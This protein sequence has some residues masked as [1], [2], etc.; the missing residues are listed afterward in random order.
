M[1]DA[2]E[3]IDLRSDT[4]TTPSDAMRE[5]AR[6]ADV[7]DD[8]Y[9]DDPTVNELERRAAEA[10]GT[11]AALYVPS[12]TMANQIAVH[13]HTEPGQ[14]LLLE[15]ESHIY[16]WELGGASK[17]SGVQTRTID[18][19]DR[20]VPTP[21]AVTEGL[22]DEDL[23]RPGTGLLSLENTHNY[24]GGTAIPVDEI[25]AAADAARDADVPVHLD[26]ARVFNAA[27]ALGVDASEIVAPVDSVT[28]CLSKG[29]GAPVGS[30]LAGDEAFVE[31]ARR[32][33]KLFG[34]GMRQAGMIAAPGLLA[35][36]NVD[37]LADDHANAERLAA[38]LDALGGVDVPEPD[39]NI[40]VV[41]T[42]DAG[43]AASD[44]VSACADAGVGCVEFD[45]YTT[46][47]TTHLDVDADAVA[48]AVDRIGDA[49]ATLS[50]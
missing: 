31:E 8:V 43:I 39:T 1:T 40:V 45:D 22:V 33:R 20:C 18:A 50:E 24:R 41:H 30:I 2:D 15:R 49:V 6:D 21:D 47:F 38:G 48:E 7:G 19:G 32:V 26:G 10:V 16:R 23:H 44:L 37:R 28:F 5:A 36:E 42:E 46:R 12:G 35:L 27:V 3:F 29:L 13:V 25:A 4:V 17:L 14:E 34:G 11:E 9:R